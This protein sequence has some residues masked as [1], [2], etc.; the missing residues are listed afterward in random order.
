MK[1]LENIL[2]RPEELEKRLKRRFIY[3]FLDYDGTLAPIA[4]TPAGTVFPEDT[5]KLIRDLSRSGRCK[6]A[7]VSGRALCDI[8]DIVRIK[9]LVY[10]G[11]HGLEIEGPKLKFK[12]PVPVKYRR[13]LDEIKRKLKDKLAGVKGVLIEDKGLSL[14]IHYRL[15]AEN[16][17]S[18]VKT[19]IS[20]ALLLYEVRGDVSVRSGKKVFEIRPPVKWDKGTA[21]LWLLARQDF[22]KKKNGRSILPVYIGDDSTDE[23]A[24]SAL[25]GRGITVVVGRPKKTAADF[26]LDDAGRVADFLKVV[27]RSVRGE[28]LWR[29]KK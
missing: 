8:K 13:A 21:S 15:V 18:E 24:F 12:S 5:K 27:L 6:V 3:L 10:A 7:I 20:G 4:D 2:S 28:K 11:N 14:G 16:R 1:R 22:A 23:D 19:D 26:Y 9:G 25:K 17:L 29:K